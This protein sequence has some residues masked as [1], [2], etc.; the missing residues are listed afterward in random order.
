MALDI[1]IPSSV[2]LMIVRSLENQL[3]VSVGVVTLTWN[4]VAFPTRSTK[5]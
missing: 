2:W 3:T 1:S 4:G 5:L